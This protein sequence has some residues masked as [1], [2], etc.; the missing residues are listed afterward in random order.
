MARPIKNGLD[1]FPL[2]VHFS[3]NDKIIAVTVETGVIGELIVIK[4]LF[5]IYRQGYFIEW[6]RSSHVR[7]LKELPGVSSEMLDKVV[8]RLVEWDFFDKDLF[9]TAH[10][11]TSYGIQY[12]YFKA[13]RWKP[14]ASM[15]YLL[16]KGETE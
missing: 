13:K 9:N 6:N 15:Q 4:L 16:Y 2:D 3:S 10:V 8:S 11:L 7:L 1:Y 12:R 14:D 5:A